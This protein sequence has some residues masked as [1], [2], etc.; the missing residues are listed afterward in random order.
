MSGSFERHRRPLRAAEARL[1]RARLARVGRDS[2][3]AARAVVVAGVGV[4]A[5]LWALTMLASDAPWP[6]ITVFWVAVGGGLVLWLR[7]D[8]AKADLKAVASALESA[9]R[10]HEVDEYRIQSSGYVELEE[11]E[12]EGACFAFQVGDDQVVFVCGQE[13]YPDARFPS[14]DF[15]L[16]EPLTESGM[17]IGGWIEKRGAKAEPLR[18]IPAHEKLELDIPQHLEVRR[19]SIATL[20]ADLAPPG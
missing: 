8:V 5:I 11:V 6:V 1:L 10:R 16:V 13:F 2:R 20:E 9:I 7:R 14:L 3:R 19:A 4:T 17:P 12:D 15:S 18:A